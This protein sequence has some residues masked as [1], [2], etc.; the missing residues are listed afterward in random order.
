MTE[1]RYR[2]GGGAVGS[3]DLPPGASEGDVALAVSEQRGRAIG[4]AGSAVVSR[5]SS[6]RTSGWGRRR[7]VNHETA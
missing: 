3:V 2:F 7:G 6:T 4:L 5:S 1:Y